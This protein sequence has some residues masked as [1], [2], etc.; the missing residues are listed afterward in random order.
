[1]LSL[2]KLSVIVLTA[3]VVFSYLAYLISW[4]VGTIGHALSHAL[5]GV[6]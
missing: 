1:M 6:L 2:A 4:A 3:V 5:A